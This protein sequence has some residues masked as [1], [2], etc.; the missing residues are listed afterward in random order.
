[1]DVTGAVHP[2]GSLVWYDVVTIDVNY[3]IFPPSFESN[4]LTKADLT[5]IFI[6]TTIY[7]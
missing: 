6:H 1:M 5:A 4:N 2:R 3:K 7:F